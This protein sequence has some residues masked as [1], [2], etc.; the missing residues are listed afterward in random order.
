M[1]IPRIKI[2]SNPFPTPRIRH[3]LNKTHTLQKLIKR[4]DTSSR[5][6]KLLDLETKGFRRWIGES[7][8]RPRHIGLGVGAIG[9]LINGGHLIR[10]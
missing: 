4:N 1:F 9:E 10:G 2:P 3:C 7:G 8:A 5:R 6:A